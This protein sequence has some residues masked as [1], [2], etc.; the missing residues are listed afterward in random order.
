MQVTSECT[1]Y[2]HRSSAMESAI[3]WTVAPMA[4]SLSSC[5]TP[6]APESQGVESKKS[7]GLLYSALAKFC[8]LMGFMATAPAASLGHASSF[9][10]VAALH[11]ADIVPGKFFLPAGG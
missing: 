10:S 3:T 8:R 2:I 1:A 9:L 5:G 7:G 6:M 4:S 11:S